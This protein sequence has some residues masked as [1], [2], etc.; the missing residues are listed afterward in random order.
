MA[1]RLA[2]LVIDVQRDFCPGGAL[3]VAGGDE[4]VPKLN[5]VVEAFS[6]ASLPVFFTRDWHPS[7]HVSF[8]SQGGPWPPHCVRGT[9][10]AEFHPMLKV[11]E[12]AAVVDK[13][14]EVNDEAYS[15]LK[16]THLERMLR[17]AGIEEVFVGGLATEYCVKDTALDALASGLKVEL[18]EDCVRG[19]EVQPGDSERA[20]KEMVARGARLTTSAAAALAARRESA[21]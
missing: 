3:A 15:V 8:R 18:L 21:T 13:G 11:P 2:L 7:N 17:E 6:K 14:T 20:I 16:R 5:A 19:V 9:E 10:G 4:V 1:A 12:G